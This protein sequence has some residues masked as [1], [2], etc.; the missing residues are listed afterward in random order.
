MFIGVVATGALAGFAYLPYSPSPEETAGLY[1]RSTA[2]Q[3]SA[4]GSVLN[5]RLTPVWLG[6]DVAVRRQETREKAT[7]VRFSYPSGAERPLFDHA[8][9]AEALAKESG[10]QVG[11][12]SIDLGAVT[13]SAGGTSLR[14]TFRGKS[15]ELDLATSTVKAATAR[16]PGP[17]PGQGQPR[18]VSTDGRFRLRINAG[19]V[20]VQETGAESWT[21]M[22]QEGQFERATWAPW[23]NHIVAM[24]VIPGDRRQV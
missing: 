9:V 4:G 17:T 13:V 19:Q 1:A 24:R 10:T 15:L 21:I 8:R 22:T 3:R 12:D 11:Q 20:E 5:E 2:V 6:D 18:S 16:E 7:Y 23:S 14:F